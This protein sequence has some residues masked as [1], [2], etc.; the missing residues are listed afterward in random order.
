MI[1]HVF[2]G[3]WVL[4][5]RALFMLVASQSSAEHVGAAPANDPGRGHRKQGCSGGVLQPLP[6][7]S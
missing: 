1:L 4:F 5:L 2:C 7:H 3:L 6:V